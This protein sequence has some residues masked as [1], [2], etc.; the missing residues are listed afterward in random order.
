MSTYRHCCG[1]IWRSEAPILLLAAALLAGIA[2]CGGLQPTEW[3]LEDEQFVQALPDEERTRVGKPPVSVLRDGDTALAIAVLGPVVDE[4]N[5]LTLQTLAVEPDERSGDSRRWGPAYTA[6]YDVTYQLDVVRADG[7]FGYELAVDRGESE[8]ASY[9]VMW[10]DHVGDD[11]GG[12][13]GAFLLDGAVVDAIIDEVRVSG[14]VAVQYTLADGSLDIGMDLT[15]LDVAGADGLIVPDLYAFHEDDDG[16][17]LCFHAETDLWG[18]AGDEDFD[19]YAR[20]AASGEGRADGTLDGDELASP[21]EFTECWDGGGEAVY[22][23]DSADLF[24]AHGDLADCPADGV[25]GPTP[26]SDVFPGP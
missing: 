13:S 21:I 5:G 3:L 14:E 11:E 12:S 16:G 8:T 17:T 22:W 20:W 18:D 24:G 19:V 7:V 15:G 25:D 4:L 2:G 9:P 23:W 10:G 6:D 1:S 26:C